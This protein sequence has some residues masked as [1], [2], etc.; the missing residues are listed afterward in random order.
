MSIRILLIF[1]LTI[2]LS[3]SCKKEE[4]APAITDE[5]V[6]DLISNTFESETY[7]VASQLEEAVQLAVPYLQ[8]AYCAFSGDTVL[9]KIYGGIAVTYDYTFD[10]IWNINCSGSDVTSVSATY[11][12]SGS[13]MTTVMSSDFTAGGNINITGVQPAGTEYCFNG[14]YMRSGHIT[15]KMRENHTFSHILNITCSNITMTKTTYMFTGGAASFDLSCD[16]GEDQHFTFSGNVNFNGNKDCSL[17]LNGKTY[18]F[19]I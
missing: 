16:T 12:S 9:H 5:D 7:G 17:I 8:P 3:L 2:F 11:H 19:Q 4:E 14:T 15:S 6:V 1:F 13:N 18:T 10:W